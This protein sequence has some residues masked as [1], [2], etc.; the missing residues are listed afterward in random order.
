[1]GFI[2]KI[3]NGHCIQGKLFSISRGENYD[4]FIQESYK[5]TTKI[6]IYTDNALRTRIKWIVYS[7]TFW[8][9]L[10]SYTCL[11]FLLSE[12]STER[13]CRCHK[14]E[15]NCHNNSTYEPLN[16]IIIIIFFILLLLKM[17]CKRSTNVYV[18]RNIFQNIFINVREMWQNKTVFI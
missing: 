17:S 13:N 6:V 12:S 4:I 15:R 1:M 18:N 3:R 14:K 7:S 5:Y 16:D 8:A 9:N 11:W 10:G 2:Y